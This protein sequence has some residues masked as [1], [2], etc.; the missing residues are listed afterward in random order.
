M[1]EILPEFERYQRQI[2]L[3]NFGVKAQEN[4]HS[5]SVAVIG[6]GG[7]GSAALPILA[8]S[9]IGKILIIDCDEVSL[10]NLHRQTIY[11]EA[12][13]SKPK[14]LLAKE[15]LLAANSAAK[16][17]ALN[18]KITCAKEVEVLLKNFDICIDATDSFATR[19]LISDACQ[20]LQIPE[21]YA[22]AEGYVAQNILFGE[23]FYLREFL[24]DE[25]LEN[26]GSQHPAIFP[27][28]AHLSGIWA[29]ATAIKYLAKI[30]KFKTATI[31]YYNLLDDNFKALNF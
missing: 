30:E 6:A 9:G 16:I 28:A 20:S 31:K 1:N 12:D 26:E 17:E 27:A 10:T 4:L 13:L 29:A 11:T 18:L 21:I 22:S 7:V 5:S 25:S 14:A 23:N 15:K 3:E 24:A 19:F 2:T 8:S